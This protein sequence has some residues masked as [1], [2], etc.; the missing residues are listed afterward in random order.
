MKKLLTILSL[1]CISF[2]S[3]AQIQVP[4]TLQLSPKE[5]FSESDDWNDVGILQSYVDF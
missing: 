2:V 4:D 1:F 3:Q 5:L